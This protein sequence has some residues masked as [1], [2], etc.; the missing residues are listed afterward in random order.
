[1]QPGA[2][3]ALEFDRIVD[4]VT[5]FAATPMGAE[6]LARLA[7]STD[8]HRVAQLLAATTETVRFITTNGLFPLRAS[9]D[10]PQILAALAVEGRPLEGLRLLALAAFLDSVDES[11]GRDP[12]SRRFL[13]A[14]RRGERRRG[15]VQGSV[16]ADPRQDR[17]GRRR[18]GRCEPA[19]E[20][21]SGSA[22][23]AALAAADD[24][25][26]VPARQGHGEIP[27]GSGRHRTQRPL[28]AGGEGRAPQRHPR[29]RPRQRR[30][31]ARACSSSRSARS[32]STTTSSR[33]RNRKP[34]K[35]AGFS[36]P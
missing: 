31:A 20:A 30:R 21:D 24:A 36:W 2:L 11:R 10:L 34:R 32:R 16:R 1:M 35:S 3:R 28:R 8:P 18:R 4:A 13:S 17:P 19:A 23:Q 7:P 33:S 12:E 15:V 25:R 26:V 22:A 9:N 27:A 6:R 29:H 5:G 14:P